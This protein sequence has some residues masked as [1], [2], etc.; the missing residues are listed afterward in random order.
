MNT[1]RAGFCSLDDCAATIVCTVVSTSIAG[2]AVIDG[3]TKTLTS[4]RNI[5]A[6]D[7]GFGHVVEYPTATITHSAKNTA[8]SIRAVANEGRESASGSR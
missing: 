2:K 4:D 5:K 6:P 3:G 7:S 1:V 8:S